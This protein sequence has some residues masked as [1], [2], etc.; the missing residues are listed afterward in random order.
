MEGL[1][2]PVTSPQQWSRGLPAS[3]ILGDGR[4]ASTAN[5]VL[6]EVKDSVH[7]KQ[8]KLHTCLFRSKSSHVAEVDAHWALVLADWLRSS[9]V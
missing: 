2:V 6:T 8:P 9:F 4:P 7:L 5:A 1:L 3:Q